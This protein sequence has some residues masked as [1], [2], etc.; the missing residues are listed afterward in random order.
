MYSVLIMYVTVDFRTI[1]C[2]KPPTC[3]T[4]TQQV[5]SVGISNCFFIVDIEINKLYTLNAEA[6]RIEPLS[7]HSTAISSGLRTTDYCQLSG[8]TPHCKNIRISTYILWRVFHILTEPFPYTFVSV[9]CRNNEAV[10]AVPHYSV[11]LR[12]P[13]YTEPVP[14]K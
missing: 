11:E 4:T 8:R 7:K 12:I 14:L 6:K 3:L 2:C 5:R 13:T 9:N 10:W 1:V